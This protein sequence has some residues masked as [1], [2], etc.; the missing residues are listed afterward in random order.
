MAVQTSTL[1]PHTVAPKPVEYFKLPPAPKVELAPG[2]TWKTSCGAI[3]TETGKKCSLPA[4][5]QLPHASGRHKFHLVAAP[6]QTHF[7]KDDEFRAAAT[8]RRE[9]PFHG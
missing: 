4:H 3:C 1:P 2:R 7:E 8:W 5:A 6:G 9:S